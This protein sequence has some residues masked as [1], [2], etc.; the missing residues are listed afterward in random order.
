MSIDLL[1]PDNKD[2]GRRVNQLV[3]QI[4]GIQS[5]MEINKNVSSDQ[6]KTSEE[7]VDAV[8]EKLQ[9][10][11]TKELQE[12]LAQ[13]LPEDVKQKYLDLVSVFEKDVADDTQIIDIVGLILSSAGVVSVTTV[14]IEFVTTG[15]L[16]AGINCLLRA[17]IYASKDIE[18]AEKFLK[19]GIT[20]VESLSKEVEVGEKA[21]KVMRFVKTAGTVIAVIGVFIDAIIIVIAAIKGAEQRKDLQDAIHDLSF[22]RLTAR[23]ITDM[24]AIYSQFI[25]ALYDGVIDMKYGDDPTN[26]IKEVCS[27]IKNKLDKL[28]FDHVYTEV[29][30]LDKKEPSSWTDEDPSETS[31]KSWWDDGGDPTKYKGPIPKEHK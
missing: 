2:R 18:A 4:I 24:G 10:K 23:A 27:D 17:L 13:T 8:L 19:M 9:L 7:K 6:L 26:K 30:D 20:I 1:Y 21:L 25:S 31:L 12:K 28:T 11:S 5:N 16:A 22:R 15:K 3:T 14:A 29:T